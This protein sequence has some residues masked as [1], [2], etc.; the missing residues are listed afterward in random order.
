M[1]GAA[2]WS[3]PCS[4]PRRVT[5]CAARPP[6]WR[7]WQKPG[8][9][10]LDLFGWCTWD[11]FYKQVSADKVL[12]GLDAF[13]RGGVEPRLLILDD[14]WQTWHRSAT[15]EERLTS[16]APKERFGG[17][18]KALVSESKERFRVQRF[19]VW[20]ALLG[21]W[22][23]LCEQSLPGYGT[24]TVARSFGP[25]PTRTAAALECGP[26]GARWWECRV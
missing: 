26:V 9:D 8:K 13:A 5:R 2:R 7:S 4:I 20:H 19:L 16:L 14:G 1:P 22:S 21:Y 15:G 11:A 24:H 18:L 3:C 25:R 17:D 23:G 12:A 6:G 10:F